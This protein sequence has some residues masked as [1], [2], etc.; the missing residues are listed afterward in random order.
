MEYRIKAASGEWRWFVAR[1]A[2]VRDA[3]GDIT[4]WVAALTD[5][6]ELVRVS[7]L[8][9]LPSSQATETVRRCGL[10]RSTSAPASSPFFPEP[11]SLLFHS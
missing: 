8:S 3:A 6:E 1:G 10:K 5:V 7:P 2:A 9:Y 11:V 4:G